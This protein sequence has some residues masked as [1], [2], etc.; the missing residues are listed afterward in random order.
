MYLALQRAKVQEAGGEEKME[1]LLSSISLQSGI[2]QDA[3]W[4]L[5]AILKE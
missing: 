5:Y 4:K 1:T 3:G 2:A